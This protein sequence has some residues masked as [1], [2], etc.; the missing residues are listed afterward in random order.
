MIKIKKM[1]RASSYLAI[2]TLFLFHAL[3]YGQIFE[4]YNLNE[5]LKTVEFYNVGLSSDNT[6]M[7]P[8]V[9]SLNGDDYL[10]L[11]FDDLSNQYKQ[12]HVK[13]VLCDYSWQKSSVRD[14]MYLADNNDFII[15]NYTNSQSTKVPYFHY[16]FK[17]PAVKLSGNYVLQLFE[18]D[19]YG[20]PI[21]QRRF[22]IFDP[23]VSIMANVS[24][25]VDNNFW[26]THE[27]LDFSLLFGNY[28]IRNPRTE[29]LIEIRQNFRDD[30][31]IKN[32]KPSAVNLAK[33]EAYFRFFNNE[34]VFPAGNEFRTID[35]R[36]TFAAGANVAQITQGF[37]DRATLV[38]QENRASKVYL[39]QFDLNGRSSIQ[40]LDDYDAEVNSD[41]LLTEI[42]YKD[43]LLS[44]SDELY[45]V[46]G[47]NNF[48]PL[49]ND[50]CEYSA[51][52]EVFRCIQLLKQGIHD[53]AF[54]KRMPDRSFNIADQEGNF[55]QTGNSYEIFVYHL[56]PAGRVEKLIGYFKI[57]NSKTN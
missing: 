36:S 35:I 17:V 41:Y 28:D 8:P 3:S 4:N 31:L 29:F 44:V 15:N 50:K 9:A 40:T 51:E 47:F 52:E 56:P 54:A 5:N 34:N 55:N 33:G 32:L 23:N 53:F 57:E 46:G 26:R 7:S 16:G 11:E 25:P 20:Q 6:K 39:D 19:T 12:F 24:R 37:R 22:R 1:Q 27:Q 21:L 45:V 14:I 13:L 30:V 48:Q 10:V 42:F 49:A 43:A 2:V 38:L 18:N